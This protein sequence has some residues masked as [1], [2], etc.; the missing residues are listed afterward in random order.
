MLKTM[1]KTGIQ[2]TEIDLSGVEKQLGYS[3]PLSYREFLLKYNGGVPDESCID[4]DGEKLKIQ[5]DEIKRLY[6]IGGKPTDDL[7]HKINTIGYTLPE[8]IIFI[9]NS[10]GGNF[11]LL[12][13]RQDSYEEVFYKDHECEDKTPFDPERGFFPESIVKVAD[14]FDDFISRL[15]ESDD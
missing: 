15:Y 10:H 4:F 11:F 5:G 6:S 9:A 1:R 2:V 3:L 14:G 8:G 12:S 13:L 7:I